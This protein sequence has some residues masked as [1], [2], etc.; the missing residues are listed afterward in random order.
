MF[1]GSTISILEA[2]RFVSAFLGAWPTLDDAILIVSELATNAIRH[3]HSGR[4]GGRFVVTLEV[5]GSSLRVEVRD[6]GGPRRPMLFPLCTTEPGGRG[7]AIVSELS[8]KWGVAGDD[9]GRTV[10]AV[11]EVSPLALASGS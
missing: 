6:E 5:V 4:P 10:W 3:S 2:R 11:L 9:Y 7:L 1:L 8:A